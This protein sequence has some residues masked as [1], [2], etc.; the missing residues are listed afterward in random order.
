MG[1][2]PG[3]ICLVVGELACAD[4]GSDLGVSSTRLARLLAGA[5]WRVHVLYAGAGTDPGT[6]TRARQAL[7]QAGIGFTDLDDLP[8]PPLLQVPFWFTDFDFRS[9]RVATALERLQSE[10]DFDLIQFAEY[11][12]L[13]YR[14]LQ[15]K[16]A[17]MAFADVT[18]AVSLQGMSSWRRQGAYQWLTQSNDLLRDFCE[19]ACFEWADR[20]LATSRHL[21]DHARSLGWTVQEHA[22]VVYEPLPAPGRDGTSSR[23]DRWDAARAEA[24][25][26]EIVFV[27]PLETRNG[28][29]HFV[30]AMSRLDPQ[31]AITFL[32][33]DLPLENGE[34]A[35]HL[36]LARLAGRNVSMRTALTRGQ[37]FDYLA[38][39]GR[40]AVIPCTTPE[41]WPTVAECA[42][43]GIPFLASRVGAVP[44][45]L[46]EPL[47]QKHLLFEPDHRDLARCLGEFLRSYQEQRRLLAEQVRRTVDAVAH[48]RGIL[49]AYETCLAEI[50]RERQ[51]Q[52]TVAAAP[53]QPLVTVAVPYYNLGPYLPETLASV[54]AQTYPHLD[55]LVIDD[56]STDPD[57]IRVFEEQKKLYPHFRF[58]RQPNAGVCAARNRT[59][60]E[61]R[62]EL[63]FPVD[64]DN[65]MTPRMMERLVAAMVHTPEYDA[66][67]C[68]RLD[69]RES[70]DLIEG[71]YAEA[72]R[73]VGGPY[74][75]ASLHNVYGETSGLF[76]TAVLRA[77]GG[78]EDLHPE[79]V[80]E[81]WHIY[82]KLAS[83]GYKIGIVPEHLYYYRL[84][85]D[86][87]YHNGNLFITH[88]QI[89]NYYVAR[90]HELTEP[91][92]VALWNLLVSLHIR[93]GQE[94]DRATAL[95]SQAWHAEA[96]A[97]QLNEYLYKTRLEVHKAHDQ[98][99]ELWDALQKQW[100][101]LSQQLAQAHYE[102]DVLAQELAVTRQQL[103]QLRYRLADRVNAL[104]KRLPF[105]HHLG[106][107]VLA[108]GVRAWQQRF[109]GAAR[110]R[111][112]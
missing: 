56:G 108:N 92:R 54:A 84:R 14:T 69:F 21:L 12:A 67:G 53:A 52:R 28:L 72:Y 42:V 75:M 91:E 1:I 13:G 61:A 45:L 83:L 88:Q 11:Q 20:Q 82:V 31:L 22:A 110:K 50:R 89:L 102:R 95:A 103:G 81:D 18:L 112:G 94:R 41:G 33:P 3:S 90:T 71:K 107:T 77:V 9:M 62:G 4:E 49:A 35:S 15:T 43:R 78:Y 10:H 74:L 66:V 93:L 26:P 104:V 40:L 17:G 111:A 109:S 6:V 87:R 70:S 65:I 80:S 73:P 23:A 37:A 96:R 105:S 59:L 101:Q 30:R 25:P 8:V 99:R 36:I 32:G 58:L 47:V 38:A 57:S 34:P 76:R 68:F 7:T 39:G 51:A 16:R 44:E 27:G 85:G 5:G 29:K 79:Y 63:Y 86:S 98:S 100:Q 97:T 64:A 55:V 19:K 46:A 2:N 24:W 60:E 48:N 106:K